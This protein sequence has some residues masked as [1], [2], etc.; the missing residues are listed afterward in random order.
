MFPI[1]EI[2]TMLRS[3]GYGVY[4]QRGRTYRQR[5]F[6]GNVLGAVGPAAHQQVLVREADDAVQRRNIF[7]L[8][9][10]AASS[11]DFVALVLVQETV[12]V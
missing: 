1:S 11:K 6:A 9:Q 5:R 3:H 7:V 2:A 10:W 4:R 8:F 12:G